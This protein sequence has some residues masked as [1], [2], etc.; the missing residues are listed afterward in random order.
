MKGEVLW[1]VCLVMAIGSAMGM[2]QKQ[3]HQQHHGRQEY[4]RFRQKLRNHAETRGGAYV[5]HVPEQFLEHLGM[6]TEL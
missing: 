1:L 4:A 6:E 5:G 3:L 2:D